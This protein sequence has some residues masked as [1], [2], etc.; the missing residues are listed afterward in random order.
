[1]HKMKWF[2]GAALVMAVWLLIAVNL[3]GGGL[4]RGYRVDLTE[5][6]LYTLSAGTRNLLNRLDAS[7][8]ISLKLFLSQKLATRLPGI[9]AYATRV[10][11]L[12]DEYQRAAGGRLRLQVLD[13]EPFSEDE[14]KAVAYGLKGIPL[15]DGESNFFFGL[16]GSGPTGEESAIPFLSNKREEFLEY[17]ITKLI[18]QVAWPKKKVVGLLSTIALGEPPKARSPMLPPQTGNLIVLEQMRQLFE[19]RDLKKD[20][21][22]IPADVD[23]L[24]LVQ[25]F[26]LTEPTL[27]AIDQ[28]VLRGGRVLAFIDPLPEEAGGATPGSDNGIQRLLDTWGVTFSFSKVTGDLS[29]AEK[30]Q[31]N[32]GGRTM[33]LDY[34]IWMNLHDQTLDTQD[35]VTANLGSLVL[36]SPGHFT[37]KEGATTRLMPLLSTSANPGEIDTALLAGQIEPDQV[38]RYFQAS[39]GQPYVLG[40]RVTGR[41]KT[42]FPGGA[43]AAPTPEAKDKADGEVPQKTA[44]SVPLAESTA[45]INLI[46]IADTDLLQ[47]RFWVEV[48]NL[49]GMKL[50]TPIAGNGNLVVNAI[51]NLSGDNDLIR[52]R[53]RGHFSRPFTRIDNLRQKATETSQNKEQE[54]TTRLEE[55][56]R[57]LVDL[58]RGKKGGTD[59]QSLMLT[60]EQQAEVEGFRAEK[61]RIRRELREVRQQLR[62][63]IDNLQTLIKVFHIGM[64]PLGVAIAGVWLGLRRT[65]RRYNATVAIPG[66]AQHA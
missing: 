13:P 14:D 25:P 24:M 18:Y 8:P 31:F 61:V 60:P 50:A 34:P 42:A 33:I 20:L 46:L 30:I 26:G 43:P 22:E 59:A 29:L 5:H 28:F 2:T 66:D 63:D 58:E 15:S 54:L 17:D 11:E 27:Y 36:P 6:Q 32:K 39:S 64:I 37:A 41:V 21:A 45:D 48:Q 35:V 62:H 4:L 16:V 23:V 3:V 44:A 52:V 19:V 38:M 40:G 56:E 65:R 9:N 12:L 51:D 1:M 49:L 57:R 10:R 7:E 55:T 47:D 53:N